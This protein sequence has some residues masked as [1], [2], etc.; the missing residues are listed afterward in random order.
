MCEIMI[1]AAWVD[2]SSFSYRNIQK[3]TQY[4]LIPYLVMQSTGKAC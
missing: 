3:T 4:L 1:H 2:I